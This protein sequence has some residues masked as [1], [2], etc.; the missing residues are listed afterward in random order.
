MYPIPPTEHLVE[1]RVCRK[2][3]VNFPITDKDM[4]FYSKVSPIFDGKKYLIPPPT[5]C[6]DCRQQRRL[7]F[8]NERRLYKRKCAVTKTNIIST[9]SSISPYTVYGNECWWSDAWNELEYGKDINFT[10]SCMAQFHE[11]FQKVPRQALVVQF[12]ENSEF[13]NFAYKIKN[14]YLIFASSEDED[15]YYGNRI[16]YSKQCI[17]CFLIKECEHCYECISA[18]NSYN[19][20]YSTRI[21]KCSE[22]QYLYDC[23]GCDCC[24]MCSNQRNKKFYFKN[25]PYSENEYKQI[26]K[27]YCEKPAKEIRQE[28][29]N[30]LLST[31]HRSANIFNTMWWLG[32]NIQNAKEIKYVFDGDQIENVAYSWF[33]DDTYDSMD[34]DYG[35]INTRLNYES[36]GTWA[37]A[38]NILFSINVWPDVTNMLYCDS[39]S[40]CNHCFL[41]VGIRNKSYFILN[42]QYTREEYESLVPRIIEKMMS[43]GEWWE[44]FPNTLSPFGYNETVANEYYPLTKAEALNKGFTWSD[45]E[46]PFPKVEKIIKSSLLPEDITQIPD[47]ILNWAIECEVSKKP[48]RIIKQELDFYRKYSLPIPRRHPDQRHLDRMKLR[49][50]RKL[51]ERKCDCERCEENWKEK[52]VWKEEEFEW[53]NALTSSGGSTGWRRKK[54][55]TTYAPERKEIVYCEVCYEREVAG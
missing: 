18:Y 51:F 40:S 9:Y 55:I 54:M 24:F 43:D 31:P 6:P 38:S 10:Q 11:L 23:I 14:C 49:N 21:Q 39:C 50:P 3:Q 41:S 2:C 25:M 32:D 48:F 35:N 28:F 4:E 45:Y 13:L 52:G 29:F 5:L 1:N 30:F 44:F 36:L 27:N 53:M 37:T 15:C 22:S 7:S 20:H 47:D 12:Q 19:C 42:K 46:A 17:D 34:L 26:L 8:H 16:N 33:V